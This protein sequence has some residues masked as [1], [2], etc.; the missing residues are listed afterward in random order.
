MTSPLVIDGSIMEGGGQ[1]I[2]NAFSYAC[3][4]KRNLNI[5]NIRG[6]RKVPGLAAQ[7]LTGIRLVKDISNGTLIGDILKSS[8]IVFKSGNNESLS[9]F[10]A[11]TKTAGSIAL[12]IQI[13]LPCL[14]FK[15]GEITCEFIGG[16]NVD[17]SP[18]IDY[19]IYVFKPIIE[20]FTNKKLELDVIRRGYYPMGGGNV[21]LKILNEEKC[22][23]SPIILTDRGEIKTI[24]IRIYIGKNMSEDIL[25]YI[26]SECVENL[27]VNCE[28]NIKKK[29]S[30]YNCG[31]LIIWAETTTGCRLGSSKLFTIKKNKQI[32]TLDQYKLLDK[33]IGKEA[34]LEF[35][36]YKGC[37]DVYLQDQLIIY[38]TLANG[39]SQI[40]TDEL[41]LHTKTAI[42]IAELMTGVKFTITP[43]EN[44]LFLIECNGIQSIQNIKS[45]VPKS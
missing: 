19:I 33:F 36:S 29:F 40:L 45:K 9:N 2:R 13:G 16:T 7:H 35:T 11:D 14:L 37:V 12:L 27:K 15:Q 39:K 34:A 32:L 10:K 24:F 6:G 28:I 22:K 17:F 31:G 4:T 44:N 25:N 1:I 41:T 18:D 8:E 30:G 3:L 23:L 26:E 38:M 20:R 42:Y 21:V 43:K 5:I